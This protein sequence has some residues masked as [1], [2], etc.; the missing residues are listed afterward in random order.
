MLVDILFFFIKYKRNPEKKSELIRN[1]L[2]KLGPIF[3]K[4]GQILSTRIDLFDKDLIKSLSQLQNNISPTNKDISKR[5]L[6]SEYGDNFEKIFKNFSNIPFASA[7]ISD[8]YIANVDDTE[9][10]MKLVKPGIEKKIKNSLFSMK[11]YIFIICLFSKKARKLKLISALYEI[12]RIIKLELNMQIEASNMERIRKQKLKNI[13]IPMINWEYTTKNCLVM[14]K[15]DGIP[16]NN[17]Y[18][19]RKNNINLK[20]LA[21]NLISLFFIQIFKFGFFHG[22]LHPGNILVVKK[23]EVKLALLDFGIIGNLKKKDQY[24][25][26]ENMIA[27]INRDYFKVASLHVESGWIK[28]NICINTF[29]ASISS[30]IEPIFYLPLSKISISL[31]LEKLLLTAKQFSMKILPQLLLVQKTLINVE[32]LARYLYPNINLFEIAKL[33]VS[34]WNQKKY[35][36][37]EIAKYLKK[38]MPFIIDNI[39]YLPQ[40]F[41]EFLETK[42]KNEEE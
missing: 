6:K 35:N 40:I 4:F 18:I 12:E 32:G 28:K 36:I 27:L 16:I 23:K 2:E 31:T 8:A 37:I 39:N 13:V 34:T 42:V 20:F 11:I 41:I 15:I 3:I 30:I 26:R 14:E 22:D 17:K 1:F 5:H 19:L 21:E 29:A 7:S 25:L 38:K 10:V 9:V 33:N 24:Y